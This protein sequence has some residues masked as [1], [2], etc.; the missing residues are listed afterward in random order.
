MLVTI[1][2]ATAADLDAIVTIKHDAGVVAWPHIFPAEV[3]EELP[4]PPRWEAA[5]TAPE[6]RT[7][8][9]VAELD[10]RVVGFA[11][12][13]PSGDPDAEPGTGELDGFYA[14]PGAWGT[15]AGRALLAAAT[16]V[17]RDEGF[18]DATLWTAALNHRPRRIY[19]AAGWRLDGTERR[20]SF[21]G[22]EFTEVR[23]RLVTF[24]R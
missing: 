4:F 6:S 24:G 7:T 13:R 23:Y 1:R 12:T 9:L 22:V 15:G 17:L 21:G 11:I 18:D 19:Q 8:A 5:I 20:R 14:A 3:L 16:E 2:R 10:G